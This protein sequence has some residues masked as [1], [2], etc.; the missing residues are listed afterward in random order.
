M[1]MMPMNWAQSDD[2]SMDNPLGGIKLAG[3]KSRQFINIFL[4]VRP[5]FMWS[6]TIT[7]TMR[8]LNCF[9]RQAG[10]ISL[11]IRTSGIFR[12]ISDRWQQFHHHGSIDNPQLLADYQTAVLLNINI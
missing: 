6:I 12:K 5:R 8:Q 11:A 1:H 2:I 7:P 4:T 3:Q 10:E 9:T